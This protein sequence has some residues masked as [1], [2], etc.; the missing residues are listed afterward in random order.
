M[1]SFKIL[2]YTFFLSSISP[3]SAGDGQIIDVIYHPYVEQFE[4]EFEWR[5]S[6][7][8]DQN[9]VDNDLQTHRFSYGRALNQKVFGEIYLIAEKSENESFDV[10]G[11]EVE[12]RWQL[13]EQGEYG[14]DWGLLFELE[15]ETSNDIWEL[16]AGLLVEKE[17]GRWSGTGN[18]I[19]ARE[20]GSGTPDEF[21]TAMALQIRNRYRQSFEPAIELYKGED[22]F[23]IGPAALGLIRLDINRNVK[24]EAGLIFGLDRDSPDHTLRLKFDYEF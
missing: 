10:E 21:E 11:Y 2:V 17:F 6:A 16:G 3:F 12:I 1:K 14:I 18:F 7:Q 24:W 23:A 20:W 22:T 19:L 13:T 5:V 9:S 8:D 4:Q 15:R